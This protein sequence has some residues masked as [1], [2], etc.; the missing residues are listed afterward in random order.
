MLSLILDIICWNVGGLNDQARKDTVHATIAQTTCHIAC[1]Q[2]TKLDF[3]D[4]QT[5][6]YIAHR[7][8]IGTRGGILLLWDEDHI[9]ITNIHIGTH[10][11]S[12][13]VTIRSCGTS[14]KITTVYGPSSD[15]EK[16]N[17]LDEAIAAK[18]DNERSDERSDSTLSAERNFPFGILI[19]WLGLNVLG[20]PAT[21][22][23]H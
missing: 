2:E 16:R 8:A 17:F 22:F 10:L 23:R 3:I 18:P 20:A 15:A 9:H 13:D 14:F 4:H 1:I 19:V 5:A 6:S 11:L 21:L 7:P 12:A